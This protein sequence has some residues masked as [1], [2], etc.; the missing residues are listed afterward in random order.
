MSLDAAVSHRDV[1]DRGWWFGVLMGVLLVGLGIWMLLN[2]FESVVVLAL[3]IGASLIIGGVVEAVFVGGR[4][5]PGWVGWLSGGLLVLAGIMV[6]AW[7]DITVWV[8]VVVAGLM[9]LVA[10]A[11]RTLVALYR[12]NRRPDWPLDLSL[13][14]FSLVLGIVVLAWPEATMVVVAVIVGIR[15]IAIGALTIGA[16]WQLHRLATGVT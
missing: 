12:R 15:A 16:G 5:A 7:P 4:D 11:S 13:G 3:L 14:M 6:L 8:L 10:G 9:L 2:P 1:D